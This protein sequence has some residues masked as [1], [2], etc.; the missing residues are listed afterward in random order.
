[1]SLVVDGIVKAIFDAVA[2][3]VFLAAT[4][5]VS[6]ADAANPVGASP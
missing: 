6:A 2:R 1:V 4:G 5:Q 3:K